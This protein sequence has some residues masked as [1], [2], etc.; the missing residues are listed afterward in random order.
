MK[1]FDKIADKYLSYPIFIDLIIVVS[2]WLISKYCPIFIIQL[3]N[4]E[5]QINLLSNLIGTNVSL[6]GFI[7][8]ALTIIVTFKSSVDS[9]INIEKAKNN[10]VY[11]NALELI[12]ASKHYNSIVKVFKNAL[13]ELILCFI[14]LFFFWLSVESLSIWT[15]YR[16][17]LSCILITSFTIIRSMVV[18][19]LI[20]KLGNHKK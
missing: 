3:E 18:L 16:V 8:A 4:K 1:L 14:V 15:I 10:Q 13:M 5:N 17:N 11:D 7:L 9:K 20:L 12:F 19:F 6:A 2:V